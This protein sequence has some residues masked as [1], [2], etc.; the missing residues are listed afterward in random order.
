MST[1]RE[2]VNQLQSVCTALLRIAEGLPSPSQAASTSTVPSVPLRSQLSPPSSQNAIN[3]SIT[4]PLG[5]GVSP[6]LG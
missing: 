3:V 1:D 4:T 2:V 6:L 5:G